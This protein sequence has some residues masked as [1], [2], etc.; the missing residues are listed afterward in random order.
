[1]SIPTKQTVFKPLSEIN[2]YCDETRWFC[3]A[4]VFSPETEN[5]HFKGCPPYI[6]ISDT[7]DYRDEFTLHFEVPKIIAYYGS[8]HAGYTLS[9]I[10][11]YMKQGKIQ[12]AS[13][14]KSL[15]NIK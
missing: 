12:L 1:M 14:L 15:L 3:S 2:H 8:V 11:N 10:D 9:G 13:E 5:D 6:E 7:L 4:I